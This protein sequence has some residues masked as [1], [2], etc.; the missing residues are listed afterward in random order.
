MLMIAVRKEATVRLISS[1][2]KAYSSQK[3]VFNSELKQELVLD[4]SYD[5]SAL[6]NIIA[7][8]PVE[9]GR[10]FTNSQ[11][12]LS[13]ISRA[14]YLN[15]F[16][17]DEVAKWKSIFQKYQLALVTGDLTGIEEYVE[18]RLVE[19]MKNFL[20]EAER[21]KLGFEIH[22][23]EEK[24]EPPH[25]N[26]ELTHHK[27]ITGVSLNR[28]ENDTADKYNIVT[29]ESKENYDHKEK[30]GSSGSSGFIQKLFG[31]SGKTTLNQYLVEIETNQR[32]VLVSK[33][34]KD[35]KYLYGPKE[36]AYESHLLQIE[37]ERNYQKVSKYI[38]TDIDFVLGSNPF[39]KHL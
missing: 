12:T 10:G 25:Y 28:L 37:N 7:S 34:N 39:V 11:K 27:I 17:P 24:G 35:K 38:L 5:K 16:M 36:F 19:K 4:P 1:Q 18:K 29:T 33:E 30:K 3:K 26:T 31:G 6:K 32:L 14:F 23:S 22:K 9:T 13:P 15:A 2:V 21:L 20:A 8:A